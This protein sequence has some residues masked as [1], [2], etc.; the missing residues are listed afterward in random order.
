MTITESIRHKIE[1]R[2]LPVYF[3]LENESHHHA[4]PANRE[5]HFRMVVVSAAFE[6][7]SRLERQREVMALFDE[8]R[9]R[10]LHALTLRLMTPLEWE[11][12]RENFEMVSPPCAGGSK[13][14]N[15]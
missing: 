12:V 1:S 10:G 4:G 7:V 14:E 13:R 2:Y 15:R 9:S 6:G 11:K 5:T 3:E 8:E